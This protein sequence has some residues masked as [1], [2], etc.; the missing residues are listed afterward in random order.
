MQT[1]IKQ[2]FLFLF[3]I[4]CLFQTGRSID[5][6]FFSK[7]YNQGQCKSVEE[8]KKYVLSGN[9]QNP[10]YDVVEKL[11]LTN[12]DQPIV[13]FGLY[14]TW[15]NKSELKASHS[16]FYDVY[17]LMSETEKVYFPDM[18]TCVSKIPFFSMLGLFD[19]YGLMYKLVPG[20]D[21]NRQE[22]I[23]GN[24]Y[25]LEDLVDIF[26]DI[27]KAM[28]VVFKSGYYLKNVEADDIGVV[29]DSEDLNTH[30]RGKLRHLH[31]LTK[32]SGACDYKSMPSFSVMLE[33]YNSKK[34]DSKGV[35]N[36][37]T[38]NPCQVI[39]VHD[40]WYLFLD[41]MT[42]YFNR[43]KG[44]VFH[45]NN[46]IEDYINRD[47]CPQEVSV[48]W[49]DLNIRKTLRSVR[50]VGIKYTSE[51][52]ARFYIYVLGKMKAGLLQNEVSEETE[53]MRKRMTERQE[54]LNTL[55]DDQNK[56]T[57]IEKLEREILNNKPKKR[58][59]LSELDNEFTNMVNDIKE[60]SI[61]NDSTL[62]KNSQSVVNSEDMQDKESKE[63]PKIQQQEQIT[64]LENERIRIEI[65]EREIKNKLESE[66]EIKKKEIRSKFKGIVRKALINH[67][68]VE[69]LKIEKKIELDQINNQKKKKK[70]ERFSEKD[71]NLS[72]KIIVSD[73]IDNDFMTKEVNMKQVPNQIILQRKI[74]KSPLESPLKI[75]QEF[76]KVNNGKILAEGSNKSNNSSE[77][78]DYLEEESNSLKQDGDSEQNLEFGQNSEYNK[79]QSE[80]DNEEM[81][82]N[83]ITIDYSN[84]F[85]E[86]NSLINNFENE[87]RTSDRKSIKVDLDFESED[88][89]IVKDKNKAEKNIENI[90]QHGLKGYVLNAASIQMQSREINKLEMVTEIFNLRNQISTLK[91]QADS[92]NNI[93]I[94]QLKSQIQ[95]KVL[96]L[97]GKFGEAESLVENDTGLEHYTL[98]D[99]RDDM[100]N[101]ELDFIEKMPKLQIDDQRLR[102]I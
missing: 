68:A 52:M 20:L 55:K 96:L 64:E 85:S 65:E 41:A 8:L 69:A 87:V 35:L 37:N 74:M 1:K 63:D 18:V 72:N 33:N 29:E 44:S 83:G 34:T 47:N 60:E 46:C 58:K 79:L 50:D 97:I 16:F 88:S 98:G 51:S 53:T 5:I 39:N 73:D 62:S 100:T 11:I 70:M 84:K 90:L 54:D 10:R 32:T 80:I 9:E 76:Q 24:D 17:P 95:S 81:I 45:F 42:S 26:L 12:E 92:K 77:I 13:D 57:D 31:K 14:L 67:R 59:S 89:A 56:L 6:F 30:I 25:N 38:S 43:T 27:F 15:N 28:N 99:L 101:G 102:M 86:D 78:S 71:K 93:E 66:L 23:S 40:T 2:S 4:F 94:G 22:D 3:M 82:I 61:I 49:D 19:T 21:Q 48:A 91:N 75:K 7:Y 36:L